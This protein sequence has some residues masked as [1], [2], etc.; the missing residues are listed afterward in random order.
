MVLPFMLDIDDYTMSFF[1][2]P[3]ELI[4][5]TDHTAELPILKAAKFVVLVVHGNKPN[6]SKVQ[7][8]FSK[9]LGTQSD[10]R[11]S[12]NTVI[13]VVLSQTDTL[14]DLNENSAIKSFLGS[15]KDKFYEG[16]KVQKHTDI[17]S[18]EVQAFLYQKDVRGFSV[19]KDMLKRFKHCFF[20]VS[21][22]GETDSIVEASNKE[23]KKQEYLSYRAEPMGMEFP[24]AWLLWQ[25]G[26]ID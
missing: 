25:M 23:S 17:V 2:V 13:A 24:I 21:A 10:S 7:S 4:T 3:G 18:K 16:S 11:I 12:Q 19:L 8:T 1:D 26:I 22:L 5:Q 20:A 15:S 6:L 14:T 9:F